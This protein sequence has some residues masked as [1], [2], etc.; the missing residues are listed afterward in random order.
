MINLIIV[1]L[2]LLYSI[3]KLS[4]IYFILP[5]LIC[6]IN[7]VVSTFRLIVNPDSYF[8]QLV[9]LASIFIIVYI[10]LI[11]IITTLNNIIF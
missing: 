4:G 6:V 2:I 9:R 10:I 11:N 7:I 8:L 5:V 1:V 3:Y